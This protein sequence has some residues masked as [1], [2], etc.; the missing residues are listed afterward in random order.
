MNL[1]A[2]EF[3]KGIRGHWQIENNLHRTK[4]VF[5]NEDKNMIKNKRLAENVSMLQTVT[6]NL[7]RRFGMSSVKM[8][9]EKYANRVKQSLSLITSNL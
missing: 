5:Q 1:T 4:D 6:I 2:K 7:I 8:A 9:N 3:S